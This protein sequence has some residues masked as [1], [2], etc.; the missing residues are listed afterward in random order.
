M[1]YLA[2]ASTSV[3]NLARDPVGSLVL[4]AFV[5]GGDL[6]GTL[7]WLALIAV[8]MFGASRTAGAWRTAVACAAGHVIGTLVSE[9]IIAARIHIGA[10]PARYLHLTDVGPSYV[11][12]SA[13]V[14]SM[15]YGTWRRDRASWAWRI[16]AAAGLLV[17]AFPGQIFAGLTSFDIAAVGH[18]TAIVTATLA[19]TLTAAVAGPLLSRP[20]RRRPGRSGT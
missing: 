1:S 14:V 16:L 10:L 9:G 5:T 11:V 4:S 12:V 7:A 20:R 18:V 3:A 13:L 6:G 15:L 17:L 19:V 2:F 8:A